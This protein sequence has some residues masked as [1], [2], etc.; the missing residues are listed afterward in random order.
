ME[1]VSKNLR[2]LL[3]AICGV[4]AAVG[5]VAAGRTGFDPEL[6]V[7]ADNAIGPALREEIV[8]ETPARLAACRERMDAQWERVKAEIGEDMECLQFVRILK[9]MEIARRLFGFA[10]RE[11]ARG[12]TDGLA[13]AFLATED[14]RRF[15]DTFDEELRLWKDYP[16]AP[17]VEPVVIRVA[18]HG[19]VG[20]GKTDNIPAFDAAIAEAKALQGRPA[21][22]EVPEGEFHFIPATNR[23][24]LLLQGLT[25]V[26][27]R[28]VSP[29]KTRLRFH[30]LDCRGAEMSRCLN[31]TIAGMELASATHPFFQGTVEEF[32][33][34]EGWAIVRMH[35]DT[36]RPDDARFTSM[37]ENVFCLG[38]FDADGNEVVDG[39]QEM[40]Y[41]RRADDLGNGRFK[42]YLNKDH[43]IYKRPNSRLEPEWQIV[44]PLRKRLCGNAS[45]TD[46]S[47]W[48]TF[49]DVWIRNGRGSAVGF[50]AGGDYSSAWRVK[51]FP[52]PGL[53]AASAADAIMNYRGTFIG[54]CEFDHLNDDGAN[55]H[56]LGRRIMRVENGDTVVA[57]WLPGNYAP[58]EAFQILDVLTGQY[59]WLG[60]VKRA[61]RD[62]KGG[63]VHNTA[64]EE[65]LPEGIRTIESFAAQPA[66]AEE[67]QAQLIGGAKTDLSKEPDQMYR[68]YMFGVG[69]VVYKCRF[70]SLRGSGAVVMCP[71]TLI[72]ET[73]YEYMNRG[74]A[75]SVLCGFVEGPSPYNVLIRN[76]VFRHCPVGIEGRCMAAGGRKFLTAPVRGLTLENNV[77]EDVARPMILDNV[78]EDVDIITA[79]K[80]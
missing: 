29:E 25:N 5:A 41:A 56:A 55:A 13:F 20:D 47:R 32:C 76:C 79:F 14:L 46:G 4:F 63:W 8:R 64:F 44:F 75:L 38:I 15:C 57:D 59:R 48:C 77:F 66:T 49:S 45:T 35:P 37:K 34:P 28:G 3:C 65:P 72:E 61:G 62:F 58:G 67:R 68:P 6:P 12:N 33:K 74:V 16:L 24:H 26:V 39:W 30:D 43:F 2:V 17:V 69:N 1:R 54:E 60:R 22:I 7:Y 73:T 50:S 9:R 10:E 78:G 40:F 27:M 23:V 11:L 80:E 21:V 19:A 42:V 36:V 70:S 52:F 31:V 51:V 71:N 18:D 53:L